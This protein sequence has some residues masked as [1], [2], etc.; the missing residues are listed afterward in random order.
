MTSYTNNRVNDFSKRYQEYV[1][2][3]TGGSDKSSDPLLSNS[4]TELYEYY[5]FVSSPDAIT[6]T[7]IGATL[8]KDLMSLKKGTIWTKQDGVNTPLG[9]KMLIG[10]SFSELKRA[11]MGA[12]KYYK[13]RIKT[14]TP[15]LEYKI[16][17]LPKDPS[18]KDNYPNTTE[19][20][21]FNNFTEVDI[22]SNTAFLEACMHREDGDKSIAWIDR[23]G[24]DS[25]VSYKTYKHKSTTNFSGSTSTDFSSY[26]KLFN[27][28][29]KEKDIDNHAVGIEWFGYF[30]APLLG[31]YTFSINSG[32]GFCLLWIGSKSICEYTTVN[33]DITSKT[34]PFTINVTEDRYYPIRIQYY[35]NRNTDPNDKRNFSFKIKQNSSQ[36]NIKLSTCLFSLNSGTYYPY[37]VYCAFVS[38]SLDNF[39]YG[40]FDC[41]MVDTESTSETDFKTFYDFMNV[42]KYHH[43]VKKNDH[44]RISGIIQYG[45]LKDGHNYSDISDAMNTHSLPTVFSIYRLD[46]D[47]RMGQV[48]QVNTDRH[49]TETT[50]PYEMSIMNINLLNQGNSYDAFP[51][52]YPEYPSKGKTV[53]DAGECKKL[54]NDKPD[55]AYYYEY[56]SNKVPRCFLGQN[57]APPI[58]TQIRPVGSDPLHSVDDNTSTLYIRSLSF[59]KIS[60]CEG[61]HSILLNSN[62][63]IKNTVD[64]GNEFKYS[65]YTLSSRSID[66]YKSVGRCADTAFLKLEEEARNILYSKT[67]YQDDGKY[68]HPDGKT[69]FANYP[70]TSDINFWRS[71]KLLPEG[72]RNRREGLKT[73]NTDAVLDTQDEIADVSVK[74]MEFADKQYAI[75]Q[76][77]YDLSNNLI[78]LYLDKRNEMNNNVNSDLSGNSLLYFRNQ[79]IPTL[80]EQSAFDANESGFM[81][82]SLYILGTMT[83]VSLLILAVLLAR[84]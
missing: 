57:N 45:T 34:L 24:Y 78:P 82:N 26:N 18:G 19:K 30:K 11:E 8:A 28:P 15:G 52:F 64:Y 13:S 59:P 69:D 31:E 3:M 63:E 33:A 17:I 75:N 32:S 36:N 62:E 38:R 20:N 66:S 41:Y 48:F 2:R 67:E 4:V 77:L 76:N 81:Q 80:K 29:P 14:K 1:D 53:K 21:Y 35:A 55:C 16:T 72:M 61:S 71:I 70:S 65:N 40:K 12:S 74:E 23:F 44:D 49:D 10:E 47:I 79:R 68:I 50:S 43:I 5:Q 84:E 7:P 58:Y 37:L 51:Y 25:K 39:K 83:A 42:Q 22:E 27:I 9:W 56:K 73:K 60:G 54:C 46:S 6:L